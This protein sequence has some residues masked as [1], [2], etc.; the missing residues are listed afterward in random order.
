MECEW[1]APCMK[2]GIQ[3]TLIKKLLTEEWYIPLV[4]IKPNNDWWYGVKRTYVGTI[5]NCTNVSFNSKTRYVVIF[6]DFLY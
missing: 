4:V 2:Y 1:I 6:S 3:L 5:F